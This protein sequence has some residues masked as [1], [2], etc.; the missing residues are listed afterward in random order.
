MSI[1]INSNNVYVRIL[2]NET[3]KCTEFKEYICYVKKV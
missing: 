3:R 1:Y 2:V